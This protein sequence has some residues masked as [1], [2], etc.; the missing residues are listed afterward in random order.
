MNS[1]VANHSARRESPKDIPPLHYDTRNTKR[2]PFR[3]SILHQLHQTKKITLSLPQKT[4]NILTHQ[5]K[6]YTLHRPSPPSTDLLGNDIS[7]LRRRIRQLKI[8]CF[9][10]FLVEVRWGN[11]S[12]VGMHKVFRMQWPLDQRVRMRGLIRPLYKDWK[13]H[14]VEKELNDIP[15][16]SWLSTIERA[17]NYFSWFLKARVIA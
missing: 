5:C 8:I 1:A 15:M 4:V 3:G 2:E 6:V 16:R 9:P 17:T 7:A 12:R 11:Y 14:D 13:V 10:S